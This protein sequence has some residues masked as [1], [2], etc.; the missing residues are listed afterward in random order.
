MICPK[1]N[2]KNPDDSKFCKECAAPLRPSKEVSVTRTIQT[3]TGEFKK[4]TIFAKK[5]KIIEK[6]G[7]GGMG[8]VCKAK[9][10]RLERTV[11]LKFL[12]PELDHQRQI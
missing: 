6:L 2:T 9:D 7:E 8:V 10:T 5:Y 4:D 11:A 12:A 3:P 1:C